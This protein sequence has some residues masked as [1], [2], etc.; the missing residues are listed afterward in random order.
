MK[1]HEILNKISNRI[2]KHPGY[3]KAMIRI[4][5]NSRA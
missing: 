3:K 5:I 4:V 2:T 1:T